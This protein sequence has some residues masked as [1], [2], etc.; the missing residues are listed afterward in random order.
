MMS[1]VHQAERDALDAFGEVVDAL[2]RPIRDVRAM[3]RRDLRRPLR[4]GAPETANLERHSRVSE[5]ASD[6]SNPSVGEFGIG[7]FVCLT[8]HL[9][10]V[11]REPHFLSRVTSTQQ[12]EHSLM[13]V[14]GKSFTKTTRYDADRSRVAHSIRS[15][16]A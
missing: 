13:L 11:P 2:G 3:P 4:D 15:R 8:D 7:V 10:R 16:H 6:L 5:V 14:I 12:T 1:E 9:L